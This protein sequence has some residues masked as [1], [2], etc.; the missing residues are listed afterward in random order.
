MEHAQDRGHIRALDGIRGFAALSVF[1]YHALANSIEPSSPGM[2][3]LQSSV[4][5]GWAGVDLFFIL[6]GFLITTI[7]LDAKPSLNYFQV[8]YARRALRILPVYYLVV[9]LALLTFG[10]HYGFKVQIFYWL[11]LANLPQAFLGDPSVIVIGYFLQLWSLAIEEQFY[12]VWPSVVRWMSERMLAYMCLG[13]ILALFGIRNLPL[14]LALN[15]RWPELLYRLTPFRIDTL[16]G[17]A[18]LAVIVH[19]RPR[20][21]DYRSYLRLSCIASGCL[22]VYACYGRLHGAGNG[23]YKALY[24]IRFG[25]TSLILCGISLIALSLS[26]G[27]LTARV[28]SNAFLRK[29]GKYSYFFYLIHPYVIYFVLLH[30]RSLRKV[31]SVFGVKNISGNE[32]ALISVPLEILIL[33]GLCALSWNLF[34]GPILRLKR[35]FRYQPRPEHYLA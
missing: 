12:F 23:L 22:F 7:L 31:L 10:G 6:S 27:T 29:A 33:F 18:L 20:W 14:V 1:A 4:R 2:H 21:L 35:H 34:E 19:N 13:V 15:S 26:P 16:C 9:S 3:L 30:G 28:F 8:F 32:V 24:V 11:N 25:Y 17:G 5:L